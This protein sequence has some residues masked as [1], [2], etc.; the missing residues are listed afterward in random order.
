MTVSPIYVC[1][2]IIPNE[3][4]VVV[5]LQFFLYKL[6]LGTKTV[7]LRNDEIKID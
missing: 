5:N 4:E 3:V 6:K 2:N 7:S 1:T